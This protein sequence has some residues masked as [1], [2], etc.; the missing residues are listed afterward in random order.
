MVLWTGGL[1]ISA[2]LNFAKDKLYQ[3]APTHQPNLVIGFE[4]GQEVSKLVNQQPKQKAQQWSVTG[5]S[6][7]FRLMNPFDN[8]ALHARTDNRL[9]VTE[10]N[11]SDESQLWTVNR[12]GDFYQITPPIVRS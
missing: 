11:G 6:G 12:K 4:A 7:S 3:L 5:L 10:N 2:Q 8:L 1:E 9:G